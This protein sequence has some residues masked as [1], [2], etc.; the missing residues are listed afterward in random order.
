MIKFEK[1]LYRIKELIEKMNEASRLDEIGQSLMTD[2]EWDEMY[3]ELKALENETGVVYP[4]SPTQTIYYDVKNELTKIEHD[5][6]M[7]SLDKTKDWN[8]FLRYFGD[9]SV[10]G[11][12]KLDGLTCS[13]TYWDGYLIKAETRG[14]GKV[15]EDIL[16]NA[17]VVKSIPKQIPYK[18][19]LVVDGE[20]LCTWKDFK[21]FEGE[22]ANPRNF[23]SGSIRLLNSTECEKR[24]LTFVAWNV[25]EGFQNGNRFIDNL[26]ALE[27]EGFIVVPWTSS[28]DFDAKEFLI[29]QAAEEGYPIDGLVGR[30][31]DIE[32]G[33]SLGETDHH[34]K[35]AYAFKFYDETYPTEILDIEWSIGR[36][37]VLTPIAV[38]KPIE[39]DGSVV[40]RASLHN[41]SVMFE[42]LNGG[43]FVGQKI[44]VFKA[45][46][47]IPQI[48]AGSADPHPPK[49]AKMIPLIEVCPVCGKPTLIKDNNDVQIMLCD[50]PACEG[51][52]INRLDHFCGKKGLDI[53]G[54][55]KATLEKLIDWGWVSD[56]ESIFNL[57]RFAE[58]WKTKPGFGEKSV[59]KIISAIEEAK[60]CT[61]EQF[62]ASLG[63]PLIG[64]NVAKELTK[65]IDT[66]TEL[67]EL[68]DNKFDFSQYEGFASAKTEA[69]LNFDY[70]QADEVFGYLIFSKNND[71]II[72]QDKL[73]NIS[74]VI[75][76]TLE[77]FK[78]RNELSDLITSNGG[79]VVS[80]VSKNVNYLI[81][82]NINSTSAK[83]M[84]AKKLNIPIITEK[85]FLEKFIDL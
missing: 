27:H 81:N 14:N 2:Q 21:A 79:K 17:R 74:F 66:Y 12:P 59:E 73:K 51:K 13:L 28:F 25:V 11:M 33:L 64:L 65:H 6:K 57:Y 10:V 39:I 4:N 19:K 50:N 82:N 37:G 80:G 67:R 38:F 43:S 40:E 16:H 52:L 26:V 71:K 62:I 53:K 75:T 30:F 55:S 61:L 85:E 47:I 44:E 23:A 45:N 76:G 69:L 34:S 29:E 83:N 8:E 63:I 31:D 72:S 78:N 22:Y 24:N 46:M 7:L 1:R 68:I 15:G 84:S 56:L 32:Y 60:H 77:S 41:I 70:T 35:A 3:Y 5:H 20:I 9:K 36:T 48:V 58:V 54:L 42:T 49:D 18:G